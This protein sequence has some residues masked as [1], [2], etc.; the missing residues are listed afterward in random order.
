MLRVSGKETVVPIQ[1]NIS[2]RRVLYIDIDIHHADAV[3]AAFYATDRVLTVSFHRH[4]PGFFPATS[5]SISE[6]GE[7]GTS[8]FGYN[9]NVPLPAGIDDVQFIRIYR[10]ALFGLGRVYDPHAVVLCVGADGLEGDALISGSLGNDS[11]TGE[12]WALSPEG[13]AECVRVA[14]AFCAGF[15]EVDICVPPIDK[16]KEEQNLSTFER[17]DGPDNEHLHN[18]KP[19]KPN[20]GKRLKLLILGGGGYVS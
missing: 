10:R 11:V 7:V 1:R 15:N 2:S 14:A 12:G 13:L 20:S 4:S 16:K 5:G 6:K 9:L 8:G 3:Q 18:V 19:D 17:L